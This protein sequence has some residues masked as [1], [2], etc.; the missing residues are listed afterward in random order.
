MKDKGYWYGI[1]LLKGVL[2]I[3]V[4]LSHILPGEI[5]ESFGRYLIYSFHMPVFIGISGYLLNLEGFQY[6]IK[7][8]AKRL[9]SRLILPWCL[10]VFLYNFYNNHGH[11]IIKDLVYCFFWAYYHLWYVTAYI[12]YYLIT[13]A[14]WKISEWLLKKYSHYRM[15]LLFLIAGII[16]IMSKFLLWDKIISQGMIYKAFDFAEHDFKPYY[17]IFFV[18]GVWLRYFYEC[19]KKEKE[20]EFSLLPLNTVITDYE[21]I[22]FSALAIGC[23]MTFAGVVV[24]FFQDLTALE[25]LAGYAWGILFLILLIRISENGKFPRSKVLEFI[26]KNSYPIYLYHAFIV[27]KFGDIFVKNDVR[28]YLLQ[29]ALFA[30]LCIGVYFLK[31]IKIVDRYIFGNLY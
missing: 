18:V 21:K 12:F 14:I 6:N 26:G 17:Y 20:A 19:K 16:S 10:V 3:F 4:F 28:H 5:R 13:I 1:D 30:V 7:K 27:V 11:I 29:F 23:V 24:L 25:Y 8:I 22:N 31:K 9:F 2:I 15:L